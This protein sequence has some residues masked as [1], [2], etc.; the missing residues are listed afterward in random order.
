M[1]ATPKDMVEYCDS[2]GEEFHGQ[3]GE[4]DDCRAER[5]DVQEQDKVERLKALGFDNEAD[6]REHQRVMQASKD[7]AAMQKAASIAAGSTAFQMETQSRV[8]LVAK[9]AGQ[10]IE[11]AFPWGYR[12]SES[13]P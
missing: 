6:Y 9:A 12:S 7:L 5:D 8:D 3:I 13:A 10:A 4:C 1:A 11:T 2:C